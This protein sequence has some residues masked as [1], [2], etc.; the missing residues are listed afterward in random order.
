MPA[1]DFAADECN[2]SSIPKLLKAG[3]L[4][5][6]EILIFKEFLILEEGSAGGGGIELGWFRRF[7]G[8]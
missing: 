7:V 6:G 1:P 3:C 8:P 4:H 2:A 5:L